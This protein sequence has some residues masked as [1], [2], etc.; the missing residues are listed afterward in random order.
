MFDID[1]S[2]ASN[3]AQQDAEVYPSV[4]TAVKEHLGIELKSDA[5]RIEVLVVHASNGLRQTS[6][7]GWVRE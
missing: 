4:Y 6:G 7:T 3:L 5:A 1:I 2:V